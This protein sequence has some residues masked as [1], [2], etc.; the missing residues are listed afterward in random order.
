MRV[1]HGLEGQTNKT[2]PKDPNTSPNRAY[3][4]QGTCPQDLP[5]KTRPFR[6]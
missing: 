3:V 2:V 6:A 1:S 4:S 5:R